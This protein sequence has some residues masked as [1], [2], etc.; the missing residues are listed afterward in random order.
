MQCQGTLLIVKDA[1]VSKQ[2]YQDILEATVT[3]DLGAHVVFSEGF[4]LLQEDVWRDFIEV[5]QAER[6]NYKHRTSELVFEVEDLD[7]FMRRVAAYPDLAVLH[8]VKEFPWGQR[9]ARFFDPDGH[10]FEVGESMKV[11][12]KRFLNSGMTVEQVVARVE[13]PLAFVEMCLAEL[14]KDKK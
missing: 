9:V 11:V 4:F 5:D 7:A 14:E 13:F 10:A 3:I 12:T 6:F 8:P 2:F 1:Q